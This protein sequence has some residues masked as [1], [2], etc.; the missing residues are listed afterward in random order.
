MSSKVETLNR[1][2]DSATGANIASLG[3]MGQLQGIRLLARFSQ[4]LHNRNTRKQLSE[5]PDYLLHDIGLDRAQ[6]ERELRKRFW[7]E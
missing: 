2:H 3:V 1:H 5:M 6:L 7:Q 4:W